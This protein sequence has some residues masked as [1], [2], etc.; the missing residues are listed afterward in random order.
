MGDS[1]CLIQMDAN[2]LP[3]VVE[4]HLSLERRC[5]RLESEHG[6]HNTTYV[7]N[8]KRQTLYDYCSIGMML[9]M[10]ETIFDQGNPTQRS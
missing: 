4:V 7:G 6:D 10:M 8:P 2:I 9:V 1:R 5:P 3:W